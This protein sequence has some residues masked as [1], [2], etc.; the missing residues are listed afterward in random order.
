MGVE[1]MIYL[2]GAVCVCMI[3]F[4]VFY[5]IALK[6]SH[7]RMKKRCERFKAILEVQFENIKSGRGV[8]KEHLDEL[9]HKM[10]KVS[11]LIVF[12]NVLKEE[13]ELSP[14]VTELYLHE[15]QSV[16]LYLALIYK[17]KDDMQAA[18]FTY[19]LS[20][21]GI[22]KR[23][24]IDSLQE[25]LLDYVKRNNLYCRL[26][27]LSALYSFA[28][29]EYIAR[30]VKLQ[31]DGKV[32]IHE[33]I[34]T[35]GLLTFSGDYHRLIDLLWRRRNLFTPHTQLAISNYVRFKTGDYK[36]Q[37]FSLMQDPNTEK[38]LR[39]SAIRYFGKY[40]YEPARGPLLSFVMDKAPEQWEF[41]TVAASSLAQYHGE[42]VI[43]VLKEALH[44]GNW[45]IRYS[46]AQ[47]LEAHHVAY[48]E[49]MDIVAG[50]DR[51]A[52]EMITYRL[53]SRKLQ[54]MEAQ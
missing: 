13:L 15:I 26:N 36:E 35:E 29:V 39:I 38:E 4:N 28:D 6:R 12:D 27:A 20:C 11:H 21:Y 41:A 2:Y 31:D 9:R 51:Y 46:A 18:Y 10:K 49:L 37:M 19:F 14:E 25:L 24:P 32:F 45:Y 16:I 53:E 3:V 5:N 47:S 48:G 17:E 23:L 42:D 40:Y 1:V 43:N 8:Q 54:E 52:R 44:S 34:L 22:H 33:K 7:P 30:A 50:N